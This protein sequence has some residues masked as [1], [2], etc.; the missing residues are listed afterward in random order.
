MLPARQAFRGMVGEGFLG[1]QFDVRA[2]LDMGMLLIPAAADMVVDRH[3]I[4]R[5]AAGDELSPDR[6][7]VWTCGDITSLSAEW[8]PSFAPA[9]RGRD[10]RAS[11]VG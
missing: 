11:D 2:L 7:P 3:S 5:H 1:D 6:L 8:I 4:R 10:S 9:C